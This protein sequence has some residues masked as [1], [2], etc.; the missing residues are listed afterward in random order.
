MTVAEIRE[1]ISGIERDGSARAVRSLPFW[2][3][4][5]QLARRNEREEAADRESV[6]RMLR[7][8]GLEEMEI[9]PGSPPPQHVFHTSVIAVKQEFPFVRSDGIRNGKE[10]F[11]VWYGPGPSIRSFPSRA[12]AEKYLEDHPPLT[13]PA[14]PAERINHFPI[15]PEFKP[16]SPEPPVRRARR[17]PPVKVLM[18]GKPRR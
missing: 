3:I 7:K 18:K 13:P 8:V 15:P 14:L 16:R 10:W 17:T 12:E 11:G 2:E 1:I 5:L 4:A 9:G 6:N